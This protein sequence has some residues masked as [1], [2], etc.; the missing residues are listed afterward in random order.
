MVLYGFDYP[1]HS[2]NKFE[3]LLQ[4]FPNL[5]SLVIEGYSLKD[6]DFSFICQHMANLKELILLH[7]GSGNSVSLLSVIIPFEMMLK[8]NLCLDTHEDY[9]ERGRLFFKG[10]ETLGKT[11]H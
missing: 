3:P 10:F 9:F 1:T 11:F 6:S 8:I 2:L 5:E 4:N 7:G